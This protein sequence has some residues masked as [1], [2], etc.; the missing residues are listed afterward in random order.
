HHLCGRSDVFCPS[1]DPLFIP[2]RESR[3]FGHILFVGSVLIRHVG[4]RTALKNGRGGG[5]KRP[6]AEDG[7]Q[8]S[9]PP[10]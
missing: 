2:F 1:S 3:P 5:I 7:G 6:R 4:M 10:E 8:L 9:Q